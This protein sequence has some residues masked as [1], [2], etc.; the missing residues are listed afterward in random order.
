MLA[1][2]NAGDVVLESR[3]GLTRQRA[4]LRQGMS[5]GYR[6]DVAALLRVSE[7]VHRHVTPEAL[8]PLGLVDDEDGAG[9]RAVTSA[10]Y[11]AVRVCKPHQLR[12]YDRDTAD[13]PKLPRQDG[14]VRP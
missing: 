5:E 6:D 1:L 10:G 12:G 14:R 11:L 9:V 3:V 7:N 13:S 4:T 2:A 8:I